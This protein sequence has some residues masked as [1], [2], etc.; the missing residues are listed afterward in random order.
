MQ[1]A[2]SRTNISLK[3]QTQTDQL[4]IAVKPIVASVRWADRT[5]RLA[6]IAKKTGLFV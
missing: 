5:M 6:V 2:F 1:Y 3:Q 4:C